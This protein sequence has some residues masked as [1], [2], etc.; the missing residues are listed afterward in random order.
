MEVSKKFDKNEVKI[1][2][3]KLQQLGFEEHD[4]LVYIA[5]LKLGE[6]GTSSIIR[7][8]GLHGQYVYDSLERLEGNGLA[9]HI[10]KRGRRKYSAKSPKTLV[11][12]AEGRKSQAETI[13]SELSSLMTL[14]PEQAFEVYQGAEA[15]VAHEFEIL[16][17]AVEES[18]LLIIGGSGDKFNHAL[19]SRLGEYTKLQTKKCIKIRYIGSEKEREKTSSMHGGR[20]DFA[21]RY[22]PGL[23]TGQVNTNIW[24]DSLGF[25]IYGDPVTRFTIWSPVV[26][27]G[28]KQFFETL[29]NLAKE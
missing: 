3:D 13:A 20:R 11:H 15:Y 9:Q 19:G 25:N 28:Y 5:L 2:T 29:W 22:L 12:M 8:T 1:L 21:I 10:I 16:E 18:E 26:A 4:A 14:P 17:K 24:P 27:G 7:E 23:F 6:T